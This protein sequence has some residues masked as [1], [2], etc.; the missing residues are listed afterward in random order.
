MKPFLNDWLASGAR[1]H[2]ITTPW[3][4]GEAIDDDD[5][6]YGHGELHFHLEN[7][8]AAHTLRTLKW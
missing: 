6:F 8:G 7:L 1:Y 2:A 4:L 3:A 5:D